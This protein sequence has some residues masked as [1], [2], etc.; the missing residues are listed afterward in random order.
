[1]TGLGRRTL[2]AG[3]AA[4]LAN[5]LLPT[6]LLAQEAVVAEFQPQ[7]DGLPAGWTPLTFRNISRHTRYA[8]VQEDGRPILRAESEGAASGLIRRVDLDPGT[9]RHLSWR[10]KIENT[11]AKGDERSKAGDDYAARIYVAFRYEP[12]TAGA[13]ER[14]RYGAARLLYGEYPPKHVLNYIWAN[15]LP[16][17]EAIDNAFTDRAKMIA[18]RSGSAEAGQWLEEERNVYADYRRLFGQE[19]PR[20]AGIAVMTDTDNTGERAVAYYDRIVVRRGP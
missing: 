13:W 19:P 10:W 16:K 14:A 15:R 9:Y 7:A 17:G 1:M 5:N 8:I 4:L 18:V 6:F 3:G 2:L 20:I 12:E 11:I